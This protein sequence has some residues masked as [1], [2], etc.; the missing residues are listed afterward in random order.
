M[1]VY[2]HEEQLT[3]GYITCL[4]N[5]LNS[6]LSITSNQHTNQASETHSLQVIL[7]F[8][9]R[10]IQSFKV[11]FITSQYDLIYIS[12]INMVGKNV[13]TA[14]AVYFALTSALA[15]PKDKVDDNK[16]KL[17]GDDDHKPHLPLKPGRPD[18]K[19]CSSTAP[20]PT[21][22]STSTDFGTGIGLPTGI[23]PTGTGFV[24]G[25]TL[26]TE[27]I[28]TPTITDDS[29]L[30][31]TTDD[32]STFTTTDDSVASTDVPIVTKRSANSDKGKG[33]G[34]DDSTSATSSP[35][36]VEDNPSR[37]DDDNGRPT[38]LPSSGFPGAVNGTISGPF[39]GTD[40]SGAATITV[41]STITE[42]PTLTVTIT[43]SVS[44]PTSK[45]KGQKGK[46]SKTTSATSSTTSVD[47]NPSVTPAA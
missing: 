26:T 40:D 13:L 3:T 9:T 25:V 42:A 29:A 21:G 16:T 6:S 43:T 47:D 19:D 27:D 30:P 2:R 33:G 15:L 45:S 20:Y 38:A 18:D 17:G 4:E 28:A 24:T 34:D 32:D 12:S 22:D 39:N 10:F 35:S 7:A 31:T 23:F 5:P 41:T 44:S 11:R 14:A 37:T 36:G 46:K 8:N 1:K